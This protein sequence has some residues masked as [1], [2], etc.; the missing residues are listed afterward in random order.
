MGTYV[1]NW[2]TFLFVI[3]KLY[4]AN[5]PMGRRVE[6]GMKIKLNIY[7]GQQA[8]RQRVRTICVVFAL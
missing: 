6:G 7:D 1:W 4:S 5:D 8:R 3:K 2:R